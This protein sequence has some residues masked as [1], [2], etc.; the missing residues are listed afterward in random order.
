MEVTNEEIFEEINIEENCS[1]N[2]SDKS[3]VLKITTDTS[4]SD[5][6]TEASSIDRL[7]GNFSGEL[8]IAD[9]TPT[10]TDTSR[11]LEV[12]GKGTVSVDTDTAQI[13]VGIEVEGATAGEVQQEVA[14]SSSAVVE[15][16]N[17]LE[18]EELQTISIRLQPKFEFDDL[19]NSTVDGFTG[20]NVLQF[21]VS[22][23]QAGETIDAAIQAGANLIQNIDFIASESELERARL[24]AIEL[25]ARDAQNIAIPLLDTLDLTPLEIVDI[26]I[27][28][29]G[30]PS[31]RPFSAEFSIAAFDASTPIIGGSQEVVAEVALDINYAAL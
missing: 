28:E 20:R 7:V 11:I 24:S 12:T 5:L 26:D 25:A 29:V 10:Q 27:I 23:E 13:R 1:D 6:L 16:L 14:Q 22:T 31:P 18:V 3:S 4:L 19:G 15:R 8:L 30:S 2:S 9:V 17:Q 21:E